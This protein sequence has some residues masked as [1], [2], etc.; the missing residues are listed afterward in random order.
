MVSCLCY[1][2]WL[3]PRQ[4]RPEGVP[5]TWTLLGDI[6]SSRP[7][8]PLT[9]VSPQKGRKSGLWDS[10]QG[11]SSAMLWKASTALHL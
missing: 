4:M 9:K 3:I 6:R 8:P 10:N 11:S 1:Y 2:N 7:A 5:A